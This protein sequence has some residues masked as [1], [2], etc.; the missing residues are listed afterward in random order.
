M[1]ADRI[2]IAIEITRP[3]LHRLLS[4][5]VQIFNQVILKQIAENYYR[6]ALVLSQSLLKSIGFL[7]DHWKT[8]K[9][10]ACS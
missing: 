6:D 5:E 1:G 8:L 3:S 7:K 9:Q 10:R 4:I 2:S